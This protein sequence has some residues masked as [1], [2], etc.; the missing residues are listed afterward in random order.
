MTTNPPRAVAR[1]VLGGGILLGVGVFAHLAVTKPGMAGINLRTYLLAGEAI[2]GPGSVYAVAPPGYPGLPWVYPPIIA[3]PFALAV[4][5]EPWIPI[6][7][8]YW[9]FLL[10][11]GVL[12]GWIV[13]DLI[14]SQLGPLPTIDRVLIVGFAV[15]S[16]PMVASMY[17]GNLNAVLVLCLVGAVWAIEGDR[18]ILGG[19][20]LAIPALVKVFPAAFGLW[21]VA[22][23]R[24]VAL[25][26]AIGVGSAV[27]VTSLL[28]F[29][30]PPHRT[31]LEEALLPRRRLSAFH[32]GLNADAAY[33]TLQRPL[34]VVF[35][36]HPELLGAVALGLLAPAVG[37]VWINAGQP[38]TTGDLLTLHAIVVGVLLALPSYTVYLAYAVPTMVALLY[39]LP[40]GGA[41]RLFR[42]GVGVAIVP[43]SVGALRR[44]FGDAP[45]IEALETA[46][47]IASPHLVGLLLTLAGTVLAASRRSPNEG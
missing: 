4:R 2:Q 5:V 38:S 17:Y 20:I 37:L 45:A 7:S 34:A 16:P 31:Y 32:G 13:A 25:Q 41:R 40:A 19:G 6:R 15:L 47:R 30:W 29:G 26:S 23:R 3:V 22:R 35:P 10:A 11:A 42:L 36:E 14:E 12:S 1:L 44:V 39:L 28:T 18:P 8:L 24:W 27:V 43:T 46:L 9:I 21:L 33:V